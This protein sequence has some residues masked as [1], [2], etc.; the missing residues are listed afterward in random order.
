MIASNGLVV[1]LARILLSGIFIWSGWGKIADIGGTAA[2]IAASGLPSAL[3]WPTAFFELIAGL[4]IL[5]GFQTKWTALALALFCL[6]T[7]LLFHTNFADPLQQINFFKNLAMAGGFLMLYAYPHNHYSI[8]AVW[9]E[10][11]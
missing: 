2:Y 3:A 10:E 11:D 1:L 8:E 6:L 9:T 4:F 7:A 5:L